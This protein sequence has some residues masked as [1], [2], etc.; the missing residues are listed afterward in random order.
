[1]PRTV[2]STAE[3]LDDAGNAV[4]TPARSKRAGGEL[5]SPRPK[6]KAKAKAK[7]K[8]KAKLAAKKD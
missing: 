7:G 2:I 6:A 3:K 8:A 1:M 4:E 5:D